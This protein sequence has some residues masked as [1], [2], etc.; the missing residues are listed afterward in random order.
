MKQHRH[1]DP[2]WGDEVV[3][4]YLRRRNRDQQRE[5]AIADL[6]AALIDTG[7]YR[8]LVRIADRLS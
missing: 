1:A 7:L 5:K 3:R 4:R 2:A 6:K 8:L